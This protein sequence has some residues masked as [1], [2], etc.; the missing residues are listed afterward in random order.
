MALFLYFLLLLALTGHSNAL[1]C[2]C[3]DGVGDQALQKAIDYACGN[4]ADCSAIL[5]NGACYQPNTVKDHCNYA[6]NSYYQRKGNAQDSCDFSGAA[7]TSQNPPSTSSGC[8]YPSSPSNAGSGSTTPSTGTPGTSPSTTPS[9]GTGTGN[10]TSTGTGFGTGSPTGVFGISPS[11]ST[12]VN[13]GSGAALSPLQG[14][15]T[16]FLMSLF[17]TLLLVLRV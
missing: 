6:V 5:Q 4:G 1:Y 11:S 3:K 12:G 9:T 14:T 15:K 8:V 13:D 16:M 10:G 17:L 7:S 2:L